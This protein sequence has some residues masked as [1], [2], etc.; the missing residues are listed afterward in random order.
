MM[1]RIWSGIF[2][3]HTGDLSR[4]TFG[5]LDLMEKLSGEVDSMAKETK[6]EALR[7]AL[8]ER[9]TRLAIAPQLESGK[10]RLFMLLERRIWPGIPPNVLGRTM[11]KAEEE[12][13]LGFGPE[14]V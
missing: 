2:L 12:E 14:G 6:T 9:K 4:A 1:P 8:L 10:E 3:R 13:L 7:R 5:E 11:T